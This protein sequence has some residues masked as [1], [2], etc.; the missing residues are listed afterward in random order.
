M[1]SGHLTIRHL[2]IRLGAAIAALLFSQLVAGRGLPADP[3]TYFGEFGFCAL[4]LSRNRHKEALIEAGPK[5][6]RLPLS[7]CSTFKIPNTLIGL[8]T[9]VVSGPED[10]KKWDGKK[11]S[12]TVTNRDH[13][14]QSAISESVPWY[15]QEL[16]RDVGEDRMKQWLLKLDYGNRDIS[17]GID[18]FWLGSSLRID[19]YRQMELIKSLWH[20][21]LPFDPAY[22]Q[23]LRQMLQLETELEGSLHG[24]TGSCRGNADQGTPDHG[25]FVGWVDWHKSAA[26]DADTTFFV[27]N[28]TGAKAWGWETKKIALQILN[29]LQRGS[30]KHSTE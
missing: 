16:A 4:V 13:S 5:Q 17:G 10:Q 21:T 29:D 15:F 3:E 12:R 25:W 30:A 8:Q 24:K 1:T 28:T 7:P 26:I 2:T 6:C 20:G 23:M 19:A 18:R 22:Q 27:I 14:L 11:R 9:G